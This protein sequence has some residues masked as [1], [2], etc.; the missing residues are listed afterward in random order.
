MH[1]Q[2]TINVLPSVVSERKLQRQNSFSIFRNI[3]F[4]IFKYYW[5][6]QQYDGLSLEQRLLCS[7]KKSPFRVE[8][9]SPTLRFL[10]SL[11]AVCLLCGSHMRE[12]S[13][14]E[15]LAD[16]ESAYQ[17]Q[18]FGWS[19]NKDF[20]SL[21]QFV[22]LL[23]MTEHWLLQWGGIRLSSEGEHRQEWQ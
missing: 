7:D 23:T 8:D 1:L 13:K 3:L 2:Q 17:S 11:V 10:T 20:I 19:R 14:T 4:C 21:H 16:P 15:R 12:P 18:A 5:K 22:I 9:G 6:Y